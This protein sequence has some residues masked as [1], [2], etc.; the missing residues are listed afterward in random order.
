MTFFFLMRAIYCMKLT[1]LTVQ[2]SMVGGIEQ[3]GWRYKAAWLTVP[4]A[5]PD[6]TEM[7]VYLLLPPASNTA[8]PSQ[9]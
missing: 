5:L 8:A 4:N 9:Q 2:S 1:W 6:G 3:Y 7:P